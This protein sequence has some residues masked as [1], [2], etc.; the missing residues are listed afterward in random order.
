MGRTT[1]AAMSFRHGNMFFS[2]LG[3]ITTFLSMLGSRILSQNFIVV[4]ES[5][6]P[7]NYSKISLFSF[8]LSLASLFIHN[9][10]KSARKARSDILQSCWRDETRFLRGNLCVPRAVG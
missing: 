3:G 4:S 2:H 7:Q 1:F 6:F 10:F 8:D 5:G 9:F